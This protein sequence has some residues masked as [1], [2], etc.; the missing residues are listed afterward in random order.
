VRD[1][2]RQITLSDVSPL[3]VSIRAT[4]R[5]VCSEVQERER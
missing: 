1:V 5:W 2:S 3:P 4:G